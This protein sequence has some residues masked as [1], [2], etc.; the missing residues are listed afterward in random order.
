MHTILVIDDDTVVRE[1][2]VDIMELVD[3]SVMCASNGPEGLE[4]FTK[5]QKLIAGVIVDRRMPKMDGF[6]TIQKLRKI[7]SDLPIIMSSG[8][9]DEESHPSHTLNDAKPNAYLYKP[10]EIDDLI[11]LVDEIILKR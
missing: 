4:V 3:V 11:Q 9:A 1:A 10:Y 8:Y 5:N 2:I 7:Q 6:E